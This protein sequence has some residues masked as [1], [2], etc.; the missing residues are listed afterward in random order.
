MTVDIST[1]AKPAEV[2]KNFESDV[3]W[4]KYD[5]L[6]VKGSANGAIYLIMNGILRWIPNPDTYNSMFASWDG[7]VIN[8]YLVD[9]VPSGEPFTS[10]STLVTDGVDPAIYLVTL[11]VK[12][13]VPSPDVMVQFNFASPAVVPSVVIQFLQNGPDVG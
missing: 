4:S 1:I 6:R 13:W 2:Q 12:M 11:G 3:D 9:S 10:G 7:I 8:D 5:G